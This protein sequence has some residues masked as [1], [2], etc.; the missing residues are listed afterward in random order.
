MEPGGNLP[1]PYLTLL[2]KFFQDPTKETFKNLLE[3]TRNM[4]S[5][6]DDTETLHTLM[7][8]AR[9]LSQGF[10]PSGLDPGMSEQEAMLLWDVCKCWLNNPSAAFDDPDPTPAEDTFTQVNNFVDGKTTGSKLRS[11]VLRSRSRCVHALHALAASLPKM[12]I[13]TPF[14]DLYKKLEDFYVRNRP[15]FGIFLTAMTNAFTVEGALGTA[16][17]D[18]L[19][20]SA[21]IAIL[22]A[23]EHHG[24]SFTMLWSIL[25]LYGVSAKVVDQ[26]KNI[27]SGALSITTGLIGTVWKKFWSWLN[28]P[29]PEGPSD[30]EHQ[31]D[32]F[33]LKVGAAVVLI[34]FY[35][36]FGASASSGF[37]TKVR[38]LVTGASGI[39]LILKLISYLKR[40]VEEVQLKA[41]TELLVNQAIIAMAAMSPRSQV[42]SPRTMDDILAKS[43]DV[44]SALLEHLQ[45]TGTSPL[46]GVVRFF[47]ES[48]RS[49]IVN[50]RA[51]KAAVVPRKAP[52][53]VIFSGPPG[54]G[55]TTLVNHLARVIHPGVPA[56][57]SLH[58]DHWDGYSGA[59]V[60]VWDE[61]DTDK[62]EEYIETIIR[63]VNTT[64][65]P[66]NADLIGNKGMTFTSKVIL[67]TSNRSTPV[68][69]THPRAGAFYRRVVVV[70]VTSSAL[71]QFMRDNPGVDPPDSLFSSDF[72]HLTLA[73]RA[74]GDYTGQGQHFTGVP[75]PRPRVHSLNTFIN[76]L[77]KKL[78]GLPI[79]EGP[80]KRPENGP[81]EVDGS[82]PDRLVR[83]YFEVFRDAT[84][85]G[86]G[87]PYGW[88]IPTA[89]S[90]PNLW[91]GVT[92]LAS[93]KPTVVF[94]YLC[95]YRQAVGGVATIHLHHGEMTKG[96]LAEI[97][98]ASCPSVH[99]IVVT[100][101]RT[102]RIE[103][104]A[105]ADPD[106]EDD[107]FTETTCNFMDPSRFLKTFNIVP[108]KK[109]IYETRCSTLG[110]NFPTRVNV[111][112]HITYTG[113]GS[114]LRVLARHMTWGSLVKAARDSFN[115]IT[116][117]E[118][119]SLENI[120]QKVSSYSFV[121]KP[122]YY[123]LHC[124]WGAMTM[125]ICGNILLSP[126]HLGLPLKPEREDFAPRTLCGF[127]YALVETFTYGVL[128]RL[129]SLAGVF[130]VS[131][132]LLDS[133][134]K[135]KNKRGRGALRRYAARGGIALSDED[136]EE[137]QEM[138]KDWRLDFTVAEYVELKESAENPDH[139]DYNG[140]LQVRFR[141]WREVKAMRA[142]AGAA[143]QDAYVRDRM[144][145]TGQDPRRIYTRDDLGFA[146]YKP[147]DVPQAEGPQDQ[148]VVRLLREGNHAGWAVHVGNGT[149]L[150]A[151][152]LLKGD[153]PTI[154][155][156]E[157]EIVSMCSDLAKVKCSYTAPGT[158]T[159]AV[160]RPAFYGP[161][162]V[163]ITHVSL[164][165]NLCQ[166]GSINGGSYLIANST[167]TGPGS[168]G[169]PLYDDRGC[170][171]GLHVAASTVT[172][173]KY[174]I[175]TKPF[176]KPTPEEI[177]KTFR[178]LPV[179]VARHPQ[180]PLPTTTAYGLS[181]AFTKSEVESLNIDSPGILGSHD[182]RNPV[183]LISL[184][185]QE[186]EHFNH[187]SPPIDPE[188]LRAAKIYVTDA[189]SAL[190]G[191]DKSPTLSMSQAFSTL[192]MDSS[193]GPFIPGIKSDYLNKEGCLSVNSHL[194][195]YLQRCWDTAQRGEPLD[196]CYK[197]ALKDELLPVRKV[198]D[199]PKRRLLWG[200][201]VGVSTIVAGAF[202]L[203]FDRI[204]S[205]APWG[206]ISVGIAMESPDYRILWNGFNDKT[207]VAVDYSRWDSTQSPAIIA[208]SL[209]I[210]STFVEP[211]PLVS[212]AVATLT[213][214][215]CGHFLDVRMKTKRGLP[216]G[217]PGTSIINSIN[218]L[219]YFVMAVRQAYKRNKLVYF[220][221]P[222]FVENVAVY[223]DDGIYGFVPGTSY[224][225][226]AF[227][228]ALKSYGLN[229]TSP[230]KGPVS[231]ETNEVVY[232]KRTIWTR[233]EGLIPPRM[234][235][236]SLLRQAFWIKRG[237]RKNPYEVNRPTCPEGR[238]AQ[239]TFALML[240]S[241]H[242]VEIYELYR[243]YFEKAAGAEGV[244]LAYTDYHTARAGYLEML[245]LGSHRILLSELDE[246]L[247][248]SLA[249]TGDAVNVVME[250]P[251][252][253]SGGSN[254][255]ASSNQT[256]TLTTTN[257]PPT[258]ID[259]PNPGPIVVGASGP[260]TG[261]SQ[262]AVVAT[263]GTAGTVPPHVFSNFVVTTRLAWWTNMPTGT[264]L[265]TVPLGPTANAYLRHLAGMYDAWSGSLLCQIVISGS[266][267]YGG[268]LLI[269]CLPPGVDP[270]SV[271]N[272][273]G[274]PHTF[275]N[276][277]EISPIVV[278]IP[279][280]NAGTYHRTSGASDPTT[281]VGVWVS[282]PL[283]NP[284][285][286]GA[287][288]SAAEITLSTAAGPDF[289]FS[290]PIMPGESDSSNLAGLLGYNTREWT[291][292]RY[293]TNIV[294]I[295]C[296]NGPLNNAWNH[297]ASGGLTYGWG[298]GYPG[299][300]ISRIIGNVSLSSTA[301]LFVVSYTASDA[302]IPGVPPQ[303]PDFANGSVV[304]N[305]FPT[306]AGAGSTA[307]GCGTCATGTSTT[308]IDMIENS[309][310][311]VLF[312]NGTLNDPA[313]HQA[314][315]YLPL[316]YVNGTGTGMPSPTT[317]I[318]FTGN[319]PT[320]TQSVTA[321]IGSV[322]AWATVSGSGIASNG[323]DVGLQALPA[324]G[325]PTRYA[326]SG[327]A[328][329]TF[330]GPM[331]STHTGPSMIACT[332]PARTATALASGR[333]IIP[334]GSMGVYTLTGGGTTFTLG[335]GS[336]G[337]IYSAP[338]TGTVDTIATPY[339]ISFLGLYPVT[340]PLLPPSGRQTGGAR[341]RWQR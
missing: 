297:Y 264:L 94:D 75:C 7:H 93:P 168:C 2:N 306:S 48:L 122:A 17:F 89:P 35:I 178:G 215:P 328:H 44:A 318:F 110:F 98:S 84:E 128:T 230:S 59:P 253:P 46:A 112:N 187:E 129:S 150:T 224:Q 274:Y 239:L 252:P 142:A 120:Y 341:T 273:S 80:K 183:P 322:T 124:P 172:Q 21:L 26:L 289:T 192:N 271:T 303:F 280:I 221:N 196:H 78:A 33:A 308:D 319:S 330:W 165:T 283:L 225:L 267:I 54:I 66:L 227:V 282:A 162:M 238:S 195:R 160:G 315:Q 174:F 86:H 197:I 287:A 123:I 323:T 41:K 219:L 96:A 147:R 149:Y 39:S 79:P 240:L 69:P 73:V 217:M 251:S 61:Y 108:F 3:G 114:L 232:L 109:I 266:G 106:L 312:L 332:Q 28:P 237:R 279:D 12:K 234:N 305:G 198:K 242:P 136:Y 333:Y 74:T 334:P 245:T 111:Q 276:P 176:L 284:F 47:Y 143:R 210:L 87:V 185:V 304:M 309:P 116:N 67:A 29:A 329:T 27:F 327:L 205:T 207:L 34:F 321:F 148:A 107:D 90:D 314:G 70:D 50:Y 15:Y 105:L 8:Q 300:F 141:R 313:N 65:C 228:E 10:T 97:V 203:V 337:S 250:G 235:V 9:C 153:L 278:R 317:L 4:S 223:G 294:Y 249:D 57:I 190:I 31:R 213:K 204:K 257:T 5:S 157:L 186:L 169:S 125:Y 247:S 60:A 49:A 173:T 161:S 194:Y 179:A 152:H 211:S 256:T 261:S 158:V 51:V 233:D 246:I 146:N 336:D 184:L 132:L 331:L 159:V 81:P 298:P 164:G 37:W 117:P 191:R 226:D 193:C 92:I 99:L 36:F 302:I 144:R 335:L 121:N 139:E 269:A 56:N 32:P 214:S 133:E 71:D 95:R 151:A 127:L 52:L 113:V 268:Q 104:V 30:T 182:V 91:E 62:N 243:P 63:L 40:H 23:H 85:G 1:L 170:L 262:L 320:T 292:A 310:G 206:P 101:S 222:L 134:G 218:H 281:T 82:D 68:L 295:Q 263:G 288:T 154:E 208:T 285:V 88:T 135:G 244:K 189:L 307:A 231:L 175:S 145:N 201:D 58:V 83:R 156:K 255:A 155:G 16:L 325:T 188:E 311:S 293:P 258:V 229:P 38:N 241:S 22:K 24:N 200:A 14:P 102:C 140:T 254:G 166:Q 126:V 45:V 103:Y 115:E 138:K 212:S 209:Q 199:T 299:T 171:V 167:P 100:S 6:P 18:W 326:P 272:P 324:A 270:R 130:S 339:D 119:V 64:P 13:H 42:A 177:M 53:M 181:P 277:R 296:S 291:S 137:W 43:E 275:L 265:G 20:P 77:D 55:K 338:F 118:M 290:I 248:P 11:F 236:M 25:E 180:G 19:K 260:T 340:Y 286:T 301:R 259:A 131:M 316:P 163:P 220:G 72:S 216:S 76:F 202:S